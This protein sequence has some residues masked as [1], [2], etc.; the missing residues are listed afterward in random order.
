MVRAKTDASRTKIQRI[1]QRKASRRKDGPR[2]EEVTEKGSIDLSEPV[3][4]R[5]GAV[6]TTAHGVRAEEA[7]AEPGLDADDRHLRH[8]RGQI[9][10]DIF[11]DEAEFNQA[12]SQ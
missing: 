3:K 12:V 11:G 2:E 1:R 7:E 9:R 4:G 8:Q 10:H 6:W 5:G